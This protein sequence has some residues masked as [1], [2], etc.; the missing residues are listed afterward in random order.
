LQALYKIFF[1]T[2]TTCFICITAKSQLTVSGT[3]YDS[4]KVIPVK[5][6]LIKSSNGTTTITDSLGHYA[7]VT[8]D[9]D[10]LTF[11]YQN[12]PTAKFAVKQIA[13]IGDFDISLHIRL[14]EKFRTLKEVRVYSKNF[15]QDSIENREQYAKLFDYQRPG[16]KTSTDSYTGA[17]G[18]DL[19]ELINVFR[20]KR[21]RQMKKMQERLLEQEQENYINY[22][23]NKNSV[24]R[25]T[26]LEGKDLDI[27]MKEYRPDF[28][29]TK[30]SS[31]VDFYQYVLN[32]SYD[33]RKRMLISGKPG[34]SLV[35]KPLRKF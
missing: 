9:K 5:D 35:Q 17:A 16:V 22:R 23:F 1:L 26:R 2:C 11:I 27:F 7:I 30:N 33:Y 6:V 24:K 32:A 4:T 25:I 12:K 29:F 14:S 34:D 3:V 10:S 18:M 31:L 21:N 8:T 15:K 13:N 20:F 28:E 19:D